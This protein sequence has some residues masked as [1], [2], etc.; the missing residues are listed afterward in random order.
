MEEVEFLGL[1]VRG[2]VTN[3]SAP[4]FHPLL[5]RLLSSCKKLKS[6][7]LEPE[8]IQ[9]GSGRMTFEGMETLENL[10]QL[11]ILQPDNRNRI[12]VVPCYEFITDAGWKMMPDFWGKPKNLKVYKSYFM[13]PP[14]VPSSYP[15]GIGFRRAWTNAIFL[16]HL[17]EDVV[18]N[19]GQHL[20]SY[21]FCDVR[22]ISDGGSMFDPDVNYDTPVLVAL[23]ADSCS[24]ENLSSVADFIRCLNSRPPLEQLDISCPFYDPENNTA[25]SDLMDAIA[26]HVNSLKKLKLKMRIENLTDWKLLRDLNLQD[27][28]LVDDRT[29]EGQ[30][31]WIRQ[32]M[33]NVPK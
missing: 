22:G 15:P 17:H 27:L 29:D 24:L 25:L 1:R 4:D 12:P 30:N 13:R 33:S 11:E 18:A 6:L 10:E 19:N 20:Q 3:P 32:V 28:R 23:E 31:E 2:E 21:A 16:G 5:G 26:R 9:F 14:L 8:F 7:A